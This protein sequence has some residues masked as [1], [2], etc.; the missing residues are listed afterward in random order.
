MVDLTGG[1]LMMLVGQ[2]VPRPPSPIVSV[3][4][5]KAEIALSEEERSG[6]ALTF[7]VRLDGVVPGPAPILTEPALQ[8]GARVILS[9]V[10][11]A[12]PTVL[13]DGII[14]TRRYV[15]E[16]GAAPATLTVL[17]R[18]L[19]FLMDKEEKTAAYP[20]MSHKMIADLILLQYAAFGI[21][22]QVI[23]PLTAN[24][25]AATDY[26][27]HQTGSDLQYLRNLARING[28]VFALNAGPAPGTTTA[29]WGPRRFLTVPQPAITVN[30]GA[31]DNARNL[32]FANMSSKAKRVAGALVDRTTGTTVEV[33]S[34]P[35]VRPP[36]S[37]NPALLTG[38]V[39]GRAALRPEAGLDGATALARAQA[40]SDNTG[41]TVKVTGELDTLSYSGVLKPM[42]LVGLRGAGPVHSGLYYVSRTVHRIAV[43]SWSQDFTLMRD[44]EMAT[45]PVV[46]P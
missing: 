2:G 4:F 19:S 3:A 31:A 32:K 41:L 22:P 23:P 36:L 6:F 11:G 12:S 5:E 34:V 1:G 30:M 44:G 27:P 29:Y 20:N 33:S 16:D 10:M 35:P 25:P 8:P 46:R 24:T 13:M 40:Q 37:A 9:A 42:Q 43:G 38:A 21:V 15:P 18:D 26:I 17:G 45:T 14:E 39:T 7:R 28:Y